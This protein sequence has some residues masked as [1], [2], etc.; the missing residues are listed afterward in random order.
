VSAARP[1]APAAAPVEP[2]DPYRL[3]PRDVAEPPRSLRDALK[4]IGPGMILAA[5]IVGSG[6]LIATT[7]LGA[8][9]GYAGLWLVLLSCLI[10][11]VVQAELGRYTIA[12]GRTGLEAL[13]LVPGPRWRVSWLV[14]A[15]AVMVLI[16]MLQV[17]GMYGG[18]SQ[19]MHIL[20]PAVPVWAWVLAFLALTLALLLGGGYARIERLAFVKV[21]LFTMLT[22]LAAVVLMRMPDYFSWS[23]MAE[24]L[25]FQLPAAGVATAIAVFGITGVGAS[26]LFMYPY[27]CVEKGYARF[28][29]PAD[30]SAEWQRRA[31]GWIRVM[32]V[33]I[34][35]SMV[36]Y[37]L[38]TAAFFLLGAGVL[39]G[40]GLVPAAR[41]MI[42]VL[43]NIYTQTLGPWAL[44]LFYL[45]AIATL[46]GTIFAS[47][48]AQTR[49]YAD[50]C[51]LLGF[52]ARDDA[53]SRH[54]YY[55]GF[56]V[57]LT[58]LPV[59]LYLTLQSP[60]AMVVAGGIAQA[61]MLPA[62]AVAAL[63][64]RYRH[65]RP[66]V[67]PSTAT[68]ALLWVAAGVITTMIS[69]SGLLALRNR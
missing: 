61:A 12:S 1:L 68:T 10:K 55:Q 15:W 7:T 36:I 42:P 30:G 25:R 63:V 52:Y 50:M 53:R 48:A 40:M 44:W 20:V 9:I 11:P 31:R 23:H 45:G 17:G 24:G 65:L 22:V 56:V 58:L 59:T 34:V 6:E 18:V 37:T 16:T 28:A 32:H 69:W 46:Y 64:L 49:M 62:L 54:R 35:A 4:R 13:D 66:E 21:G 38:A 67:A 51:R 39:H 41:D 5:S 43:S 29:G 3:D 2:V 60:V 57:L 19:T 47:T 8:Q 14:W 27:W 33:D 26:E